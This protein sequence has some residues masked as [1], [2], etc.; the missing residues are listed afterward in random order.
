M[1]P[2]KDK[3]VGQSKSKCY[4]GGHSGQSSSSSSSSMEIRDQNLSVFYMNRLFGLA[5]F[6]LIRNQKGV[7][8]GFRTGK[9]WFGYSAALITISG[10]CMASITLSWV[11]SSYATI[12]LRCRPIPNLALFLE[13]YSDTQF[14]ILQN[15]ESVFYL[16]MY[17]FI[18]HFIFFLFS[19]PPW[20]LF[21]TL[22]HRM[23][24][25]MDGS[26]LPDPFVIQ[27]PTVLVCSDFRN[28]CHNL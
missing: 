18:P 24:G 6:K 17:L 13:I 26:A 27:P 1:W 9:A 21:T 28:Q 16:P 5:P 22:T 2:A 4:C 19:P 23:G 25:Y 8:V 14:E 7:L 11:C 3:F 15:I 20:L 10:M 12:L